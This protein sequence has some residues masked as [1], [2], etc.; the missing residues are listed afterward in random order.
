MKKHLTEAFT[1]GAVAVG[2]ALATNLL[3]TDGLPLLY[4]HPANEPVLTE[5]SQRQIGIDAAVARFN[6]Q[7]AWFADAR[8][9]ADYAAGHIAGAVNLPAHR[10]EE[11][12][13]KIFA[14][15]DPEKTIITYCAGPKCTLGQELAQVLTE[16]GFENV[17]YLVDGWGQWTARQMPTEKGEED[18]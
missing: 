13:E 3:R 9:A 4:D 7:D 14:D 6:R 11:W 15:V 2:I 5:S 18:Q 1:I 16:A 10:Q 8:P 12:L 17:F